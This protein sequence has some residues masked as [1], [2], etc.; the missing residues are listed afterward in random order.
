MSSSC[1]TRESIFEHSRYRRPGG[2][3]CGPPLRQIV[4]G[5][6]PVTADAAGARLLGLEW[7]DIG[8]IRLA[9]GILG[10]AA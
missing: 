8:H 6:D 4:A 2:P 9:H 3:P 5:F 1:R 10:K 7:R